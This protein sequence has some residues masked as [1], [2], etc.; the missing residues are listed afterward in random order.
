MRDFKAAL[1][2]LPSEQREVVLLIGLEGMKYDEV[3]DILAVPVGTI[4]S[5]LS[6]A[7]EAMR[8]LMDAPERLST[9]PK[10]RQLQAQRREVHVAL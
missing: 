3:A 5:R 2:A 7:R 6:R 1:D 9:T 10:Q 4:R 8:R